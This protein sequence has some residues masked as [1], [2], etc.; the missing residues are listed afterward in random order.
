MILKSIKELRHKLKFKKTTHVLCGFIGVFA[1][2]ILV[3]LVNHDNGWLS[4]KK[5]NKKYTINHLNVSLKGKR[6]R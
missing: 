1:V 5:N 6:T 4:E 2:V 3:F